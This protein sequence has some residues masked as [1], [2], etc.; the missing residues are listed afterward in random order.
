MKLTQQIFLQN[1]VVIVYER[2]SHPESR[3]KYSHF[4]ERDLI[5]TLHRYNNCTTALHMG[6]DLTH[7]APPHVR[8]C[9][10][11]IMVVL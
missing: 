8:D 2:G 6:V 11:I 4:F 3:I 10:V 5:P 9:C 1:V 7:W